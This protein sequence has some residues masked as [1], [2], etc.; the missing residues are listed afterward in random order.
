MRLGRK[1]VVVGIQTWTDFLWMPG[2]ALDTKLHC[3][4]GPH[5]L[6]TPNA[7]INNHDIC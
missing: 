3:Y 6:R 5:S 7:H 4:K 2:F 1:L